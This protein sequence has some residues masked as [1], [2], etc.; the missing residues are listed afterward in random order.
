MSPLL[1]IVATALTLL[2]AG[3]VVEFRAGGQ[4]RNGSL[5]LEQTS[6]SSGL[7]PL[8]F[9][10]LRPSSETVLFIATSVLYLSVAAYLVLHRGSIVGDAESRVAQAWYVVASRDPHLGAIGFIWNPLPS[11]AAIPLVLMRGVWPALTQHAFAGSIVSA[12][13]M[14]GAV[15]QF[16]AALRE[17]DASR[18]VVLALTAFFALNPMTLYYGANGMSE[19]MYLLF[20][21]GTTRYLLAWTVTG[22]LRA[23]LLTAINLALG[24][25]TRYETLTAAVVVSVVVII[26]GTT[27]RNHVRARRERIKTAAADVVIVAFPVLIA[28][29]GWALA[30]WLIVGAPFAQF[31]SQYG[32]AS[33]IRS[34]GGVGG[35][36]G[37]G[38]PKIVLAMVQIMSYSPLFI[39]V[40]SAIAIVGIKR[41]DRRF[42]AL[43]ALAG[44]LAFSIL[45]YSDG[46]T[47]GFLR[48]YI[49]A[50]PMFLL[51]AGLLLSPLPNMRPVAPAWLARGWAS[52]GVTVLVGLPGTIS[53]ALAMGSARIGPS[54]QSAL[55]WLFGP[56]TS[57][58]EKQSKMFLPSTEMIA[59]QVDGLGLPPGS[60]ALD[61][62]GCGSLVVLS[63]QNPHEFIIT[64]DR[65]FEE[66]VADPLAFGVKYLLVPNG[67]EGIDAISLA[68]RGIYAGGKTGDLRTRVA[69]QYATSGCPTYRLLRVTSNGS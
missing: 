48:Y 69:E 28:F 33:I 46:Q 38:W 13:C 27:A 67:D 43:G 9:P 22:R 16:R 68:H 18:T 5:R 52:I 20:L 65:D 58:A 19:A 29:L 2:I 23:L 41:R 34:S 14:G 54:E 36:N 35:A 59:Q 21:I 26:V 64:S 7:V 42:L 6:V 44:P 63:S 30:S 10:Q 37:T 60:V 32:N 31:T 53:S 40:A 15:V 24:Y 50:L 11:I 51:G 56:A 49:P 1:W 45:A 55:S 25:L 62:F 3:N 61:T 39:A 57:S 12:L 17:M 47:F 66:V 8:R 4:S